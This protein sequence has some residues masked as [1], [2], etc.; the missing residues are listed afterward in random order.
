[1]EKSKEEYERELM[2]LFQQAREPDPLPI[3]EEQP[4]PVAEPTPEAFPESSSEEAPV[5][6]QETATGWLKVI[7]STGGNALPLP[8][9]TVLVTTGNGTQIALDYVT[10][11]DES[12][13]TEKIPLSVPKSLSL[14]EEET[15]PPPYRTVDVSVY[16]SGYSQ[17]ISKNVP[18][19]AGITSRQT[20]SMIPLPCFPQEAP[21]V[22]MLQNNEP[23]FREEE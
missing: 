12:G 23:D 8:G 20:F 9:V 5:P 1:M 13:E 2:A 22:R 10:I 19:F 21:K 3:P 7:V 17:Q 11:T 14:K 16:A 6:S 15:T 4:E 18:I